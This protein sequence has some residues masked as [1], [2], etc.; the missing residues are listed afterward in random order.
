MEKDGGD[1]MAGPGSY[2][3]YMALALAQASS[4]LDQGEFPVGCVII[5]EGRVAAQGARTGTRHSSGGRAIISEVDHAEILALKQLELTGPSTVPEKCTLFCTMEPCL[6]CYG[7][8][9]LSGIKTIVYAF[10]DPMGG[11]TGCDL[12]AL[13]PLYR[14]SRVRT[15]AGIC[16]QKSLDLFFEFFNKRTNTYWKGSFLDRYVRDQKQRQ[17]K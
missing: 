13:P 17:G 6:M 3:K 4:A 2:E 7:A 1:Q 14:N 12:A 10:E 16:R 5:Q 11:G 8:I 9:L 15:V